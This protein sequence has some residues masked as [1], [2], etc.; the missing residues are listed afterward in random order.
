MFIF[1]GI[2][3]PSERSHGRKLA[4]CAKASIGLG[5]VFVCVDT[6]SPLLREAGLDDDMCFVL[7]GTNS[8]GCINKVIMGL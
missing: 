6:K 5:G 1:V 4:F 7:P 2:L 8:F 3:F